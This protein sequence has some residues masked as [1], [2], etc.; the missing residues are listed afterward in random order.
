M[1]SKYQIPVKATCECQIC[2]RYFFQNH[3]LEIRLEKMHKEPKFKVEGG[4]EKQTDPKDNS[5][6]VVSDDES[7]YETDDD[8]NEDEDMRDHFVIK[9]YPEKATE[10]KKT[11]LTFCGKTEEY[12]E[13]HKKNSKF[14][15]DTKSKKKYSSTINLSKS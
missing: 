1:L 5:P 10:D 8:E 9:E 11:G 6:I 3:G 13:A 2:D 14:L 12:L 4:G 15:K 7:D